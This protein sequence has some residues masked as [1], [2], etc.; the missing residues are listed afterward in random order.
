MK[1][2]HSTIRELLEAARVAGHDSL[3]IAVDLESLVELAS[4]R[5]NEFLETGN[6]EV[7]AAWEAIVRETVSALGDDKLVRSW[8]DAELL[9]L[10]TVL[11]S[12]LP[13]RERAWRNN[14]GPELRRLISEA[15]RSLSVDM[16]EQV[17]HGMTLR[18]MA[19][20]EKW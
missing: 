6:S 7:L 15:K 2:K 19:C 8:A 5:R 13:G 3:G 20:S 10:D 16:Q 1:E 18:L 11:S 14:E 4:M 12:S 9:R 17:S